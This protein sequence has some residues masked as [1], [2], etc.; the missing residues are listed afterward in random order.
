MILSFYFSL[1]SGALPRQKRR[2]G[3]G[4]NKKDIQ[5]VYHKFTE[6]MENLALLIE[7]QPLTD[8]TVLLVSVCV[9][10]KLTAMHLC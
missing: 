6:V 5:A 7:T 8:T 10:R 1:E 4:S 9:Q 2:G 3:G